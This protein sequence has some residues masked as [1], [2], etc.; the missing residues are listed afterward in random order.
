MDHAE[1]VAWEG[2][3]GGL[4]PFSDMSAVSLDTYCRKEI[5]AFRVTAREIV[6]Q[7]CKPSF[8]NTV[9][10][11]Q[12]ANRSLAKAEAMLRYVR[13]TAMTEAAG[14]VLGELASLKPTLDDELAWNAS[15]F[16]RL[17][18]VARSGGLSASE[19]RTTKLILSSMRQRGAGL[20]ASQ[21]ARLKDINH[22][23]AT[24]EIRFQ[25]NLLADTERLHVLVP[26]EIELNGLDRP[27]VELLRREAAAKAVA[28]PF[29]IPCARPVVDMILANAH[30][31]G[32][33]ES[34]W[35]MWGMRGQ[36]SNPEVVK[37]ILELRA[38]KAATLG[39]SCYADMAA[40]GRMAETGDCARRLEEGI[41]KHAVEA[42]IRHGKRLSQLPQAK[43]L[44]GRIEPWDRPYLN[45]IMSATDR[46]FNDA[47]LSEYLPQ[48][49]GPDV[50]L[51]TLI[52]ITRYWRS[53]VTKSDPIGSRKAIIPFAAYFVPCGYAAVVVDVRGTG[54]SFGSR[55]GELDARQ[56][57]DDP[58]II[59]WIISQPWSDG[60]V[61]STGISYGG[62]TAEY[63]VRHRHPALR[64]VAPISTLIDAYTNLYFP[65]G[66]PNHI[67]RD[68]W[69]SLNSALDSG[70]APDR[71]D[72]ADFSHPCP[73]DGDEKLELLHQAVAEHQNNFDSGAA[74]RGLLHRD[75]NDVF[76]IRLPSSY[77][78]R[79]EIDQADLPFLAIDGWFD[80][81]YTR[82]G[83]DRLINSKSK[84]LRVIIAAASH[85]L[86]F[87]S[88]PGMT[89]P[90]PPAFDWIGE[91]R[92]FFDHYLMGK[93][94]GYEVQPR[95]KWF[96]TGTNVWESAENWNATPAELVFGL[97]DG[98]SLC[99]QGSCGKMAKVSHSPTAD[100][101]SGSMTRWDATI[102]GGPV[103]YPERS[104]VD[105]DLLTFDSEPLDYNM[106]I[107]GVPILELS[108]TTTAPKADFFAYLEEVGPDGKAHIFAD[109][110][111]RAN[112]NGEPYPAYRSISPQPSGFSK[113]EAPSIAGK[114]VK[115][116]I[117]FEPLSHVVLKGK[118]LRLALAGSD[119]GHFT[120]PA[121][122]DTR[123]LIA[124][125]DG[126]TKLLLP[127]SKR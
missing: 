46:G 56:F 102:S 121:L 8:A 67:F 15:L 48:N 69:G 54:A 9:G 21:L 16:R 39:F 112:Y 7:T 22:E 71:P 79:A 78:H 36:A 105:R 30:S 117:A 57:A 108:V 122:K 51:P 37:R 32:L 81:G 65:G 1:D 40:D 43:A 24:L 94:N 98:N 100:G 6:N 33:R 61:G 27:T 59:D 91:V 74:T 123:W 60:K 107:T 55:T 89:E 82:A 12:K 62:T 114:P 110:M 70:Q 118:R 93:P 11:L 88:A 44:G 75:G 124:T 3:Y 95:V 99:K 73:V 90:L 125:G 23:I 49:L 20:P 119:K 77:Q 18:Q 19:S 35:R 38:E 103:L 14:S 96:T 104:A 26:N 42:A 127:A 13:Y 25:A 101:A 4:P 115:V 10:Q 41:A 64:A 109:G 113:D 80:S 87:F 106:H 5:E 34:V 31:R 2:S 84:N 45:Q 17:E 97:T 111:V 29:C 58:Q 63:L 72:S 28:A 126:A 68:G 47:A 50:K 83:L 92:A 85:G 53:I 52:N 66:V 116:R 120:S 86:G 76:S